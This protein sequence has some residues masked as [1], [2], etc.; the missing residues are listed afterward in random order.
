MDA[1]KAARELGKAIQADERF[2]AYAEAKAAN[3]NDQELQNLI[4]DFNLKR[5][6]IQYEMQKPEA[7]KDSEKIQKLNREM[8]EAYGKVMQNV[9]MAN[10]VIVKGALDKLLEDVNMIISMCCEG[11]DPD[12]CEITHACSGSCA[13]CSGCH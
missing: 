9:N 3:D 10:F 7:E 1:I 11:Q 13:G 2:K 4:G 5:Q 6:N 12:T 8:Q